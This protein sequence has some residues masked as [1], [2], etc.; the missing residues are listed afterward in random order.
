MSHDSCV[1]LA[2]RSLQAS[3]WERI[4]LE[5]LA[6]KALHVPA[7]RFSATRKYLCAM[8]VSVPGLLYWYTCVFGA[9]PPPEK[10]NV[11]WGER[12]Y[13]VSGPTVG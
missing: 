11:F 3:V 12:F 9:N 7:H 10:I 2:T 4:W 6:E 13:N 5:N 8:P 1:T